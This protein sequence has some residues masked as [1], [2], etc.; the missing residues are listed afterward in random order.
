MTNPADPNDNSGGEFNAVR[1]DIEIGLADIAVGR[2]TDFEAERIIK[3]GRKLL[4]ELSLPADL[5]RKNPAGR[6]A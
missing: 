1:A 4:A 2:V 6:R 5:R 3:R